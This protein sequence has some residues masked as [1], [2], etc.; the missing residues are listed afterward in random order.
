MLKEVFD[1]E[2][3]QFEELS[4]ADAE[5]LIRDG[6]ACEIGEIA[7]IRNIDRQVDQC[8][9]A[10]KDAV[11]EIRTTDDPRI[12]NV[13]GA[14]EYEIRKLKETLDE[15]IKELIEIKKQKID[16]FY[17]KAMHE[18]ANAIK[19]ISSTEKESA[20]FFIEK[21]IGEVKYG[22]LENALSELESQVKYMNDDRKKALLLEFS[23][24]TDAFENKINN[25]QQKSINRRLRAIYR[26][27]NNINDT[28]LIKARMAEALKEQ[29]TGFTSYTIL[30]LTHST[31]RKRRLNHEVI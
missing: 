10:Y 9:N 11:N 18:K 21:L 17:E 4:I 2:K 6:K 1:L 8:V 27:L 30:K 19:S 25:V 22:S 5:K 16:E 15:G 31:Y 29:S 28:G 3:N 12:R 14:A 26:E 24:L 13:E 7:L 20:R 23:K